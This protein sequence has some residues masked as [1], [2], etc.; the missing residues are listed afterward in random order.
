MMEK[1]VRALFL[2]A[3]RCW[4]KKIEVDICYVWKSTVAEENM[5]GFR[6]LISEE[7]GLIWSCKEERKE[8]SLLLFSGCMNSYAK[9]NDAPKVWLL[10]LPLNV[11]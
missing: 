3:N 5:W 11:W 1:K 6:I 7:K 2:E 9:S 10:K 4:R 8:R